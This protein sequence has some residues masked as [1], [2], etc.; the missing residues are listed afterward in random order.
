VLFVLGQLGA[1]AMFAGAVN[2]A[3]V[4]L[5]VVNRRIKVPQPEPLRILS[6][7]LRFL[8]L[9]CQACRRPM[10][11]S[12][13]RDFVTCIGDRRKDATMR[14]ESGILSDDEERRRQPMS[15]QYV[16]DS[17]RDDIKIRG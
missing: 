15:L 2:Q 3:L 11:P 13:M 14:R 4:E 10:R 9:A 8:L 6:H 7:K 16:Q 17:R 12:V 5:W 1:V